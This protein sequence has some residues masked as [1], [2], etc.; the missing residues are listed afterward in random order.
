VTLLRDEFLSDEDLDLRNLSQAEFLAYWDAWLLQA[1]ATNDAD[2]DVY[3]HGVF[4]TDAPL[5]APGSAIA[6]EPNT[7]LPSP[8]RR[9]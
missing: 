3:A 8:R 9:G 2:A 5:R 4:A 7:S 6:G 1:Q